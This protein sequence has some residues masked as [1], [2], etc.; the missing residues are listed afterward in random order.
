MAFPL[1][2]TTTLD[3]VP[4]TALATASPNLIP[5]IWSARL[6]VKFYA[7]T[8]FGEICNTDHEEEIR[9]FGDTVKIRHTPDMT[10]SDHKAGD[11]ISYELRS[12][13][14]TELEINRGKRWAFQSD[15]VIEKQ[16]DYNY[17]D[18]FAEDAGQQLAIAVDTQILSVVPA[19]AHADNKGSAAGATSEKFNFGDTGSPLEITRENVLDVI[20]NAGVALNEQNVPNADRYMVLPPEI[21]GTILKSDLKDA[22]L[23]GDAESVI[24]RNGRIG[25]INNFTIYMSNNLSTATENGTNAYSCIFGQK[26]AITF[27]AQ[28]TN[29]EGPLRDKDHFGSFYRGL[30]VYGFK[31]IKPEAL[32]RIY[33]IGA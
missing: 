6:L 14:V 19:E 2:S 26:S 20:T 23:T 27:A 12:T 29:V 1:S 13:D 7:A 3:P 10:I 32:G 8:V 17:V 15:D 28:M 30:A 9:A 25:M 5:I 24:R 4:S 21:C 22:S 31:T 16:A 11:K 18:D 33:A